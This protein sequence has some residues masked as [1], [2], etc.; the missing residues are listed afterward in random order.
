LI[1]GIIFIGCGGLVNFLKSFGLCVGR[2]SQIQFRIIRL[3]YAFLNKSW[4]LRVLTCEELGLQ[5][6]KRISAN[7]N[8]FLNQ[9]EGSFYRKK[10]ESK[11]RCSFLKQELDNIEKNHNNNLFNVFN[12]K[13]IKTSKNK[14]TKGK[15]EISKI[16]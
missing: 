16:L 7:K 3:A 5:L 10:V 6:D 8:N 14:I 9:I 15:F 4:G 13:I 11:I 2:W 1:Y 12:F